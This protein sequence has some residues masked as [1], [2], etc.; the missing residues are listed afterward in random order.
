MKRQELIR[1]IER[2]AGTWLS[3]AMIDKYLQK[4]HGT[5][6]KMMEGIEPYKDGR[7][8]RYH[9]IDVADRIIERA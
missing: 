8:I 9:A 6:A 2:Q 4:R 7:S 1:D 5:A 3:L